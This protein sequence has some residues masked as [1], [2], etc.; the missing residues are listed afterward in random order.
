V[1]KENDFRSTLALHFYR[2]AALEYAK[3]S[4][5]VIHFRLP[6]FQVGR[7]ADIRHWIFGSIYGF[8]LAAL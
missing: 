5:L 8:R 6:S 4:N 7:M 2:I 3:V 1:G